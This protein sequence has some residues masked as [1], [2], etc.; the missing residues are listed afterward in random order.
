LTGAAAA[1]YLGAPVALGN[2]ASRV[3]VAV[4]AAPLVVAIL[5]WAPGPEPT[6]LLVLAAAALAMRELF[7]MMLPDRRDRVAALL[8]GIAAAGVLYGVHPYS[9][10]MVDAWRE[11][12]QA[13]LALLAAGPLLA[14]FLAVVPTGLYYLFRFRDLGTVAGRFAATVAG[15][16]YVG[17]GT[18]FL[19]LCKRDH[20]EG[21]DVIVL[22][23]LIA[24]VGDTGAYFAG[25]FLGRRKLYE[26]VSPKK[27]WAGAWGGLAGSLLGAAFVKLVLLESL[28]WV[29][30]VLIAVP[31]AILGQLGDLAESLFKRA[32]GVKDSGSLLPGH[33]GMLDRIDAV[34][35]IAPYVYLYLLARP[36]FV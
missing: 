11:D 32:V 27:T 22:I 2:L 30:V 3:L 28:H 6:F 12:P 36:L 7:G 13:H 24:W 10:R 9:L 14:I 19:A 18:M 31:G 16:V 21:A 5:Y 17:F 29:D 4:V 34:L 35:F 20:P 8:I 25:R 26:A 15:I 23:L 33:G 1:R